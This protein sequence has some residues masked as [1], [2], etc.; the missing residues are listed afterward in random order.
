MNLNVEDLVNL[1]DSNDFEYVREIL[2]RLKNWQQE[3]SSI[4]E[5]IKY[6][7]KLSHFRLYM[8]PE[9]ICDVIF[10]EAQ[11]EKEP[12]LNTIISQAIAR[13]LYFFEDRYQNLNEIDMTNNCYTISSLIEEVCIEMHVP[14]KTLIIYPGYSEDACLFGH[15]GYHY[16]NIISIDNKDYLIDLSYKQFFKKNINYLEEIGL[17]FL[18]APKAGTFMLLDEERKKVS[19][20]LLANGF[21]E[22]ND[23]KFKAY[24]DGFTIS[25][26]NGL[27]YQYFENS[28]TTNYT[29]ANY[30]DF[31]ITKSDNQ[32]N[33]EPRE[34][35][36]PLKIYK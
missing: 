15:Q 26:R 5:Y 2:I 34:C 24:C 4:E 23:S 11:K 22:L 3:F 13:L 35:L 12:L 29:A 21:I 31:L 25:F 27:Y 36:G 32:L 1:K 6:I 9:Y 30:Q 33:H 17:P 7:E 14:C 18:C 19:I 16:F 20:D 10:T 8:K 28:Y